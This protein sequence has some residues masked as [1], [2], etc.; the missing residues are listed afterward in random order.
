[1][2]IFA[3]QRAFQFFVNLSL[4]FCYRALEL[5]SGKDVRFEGIVVE[6]CIESLHARGQRKSA[7]A[8]LRS[9]TAPGRYIYIA[10]GQTNERDERKARLPTGIRILILV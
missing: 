2:K 8:S 9:R 3:R 5:I 7:R 4:N 1:M 6:G 10:Q